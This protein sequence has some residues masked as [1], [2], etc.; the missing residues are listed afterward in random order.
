MI[1]VKVILPLPIRRYFKYFMPNF[2]HPIV[3]GRII[4]PFRS[5]EVVGIV[6]DFYHQMNTSQLNLK[7]VI[8]LIDTESCYNQNLFDI[9]IWISKNYY[10]PIGNVFFS[11]LPKLLRS[12]Y[13]PKKTYILKWYITKKGQELDLEYFKNKK[14]QLR[15]LL[16]LK[17]NSIFSTELKIYKLSKLILEKLE[18]QELCKVSI[19][20][21]ISIQKKLNIKIKQK[22]ILNQNILMI[23]NNILNK[24]QFKSYLLTRIH[25]RIKVKFY[26]GFI[27]TLLYRNMQILILV[28][29][30]KNIDIIFVFL[31]KYFNVS[32]N[33]FH[34]K[35]SSK[36]C[37]Q[38]WLQTKNDNNLIIIGTKKSIFLPF[39][40]IGAIICL[41]EH[42]LQYKNT[43]QCRHNFRDLGILRAYQE[44]IP[45]I[46]DSDTP[47]LKTLYNILY[48]KC[49]DI[50]LPQYQFISRYNYNIIDLK[51]EKIKFRLS[52][53]LINEIHKNFKNKQVLL[54]YNKLSLSCYILVC[55]KC[56]GLFKCFLC[57]DDF[58]INIH[59]N[60]LFCQFCLIKVEKP[61][62][63]YHC[64]HLKLVIKKINLEQIQNKIK[65]I[66]PKM[67]LLFLLKDTH[68][69]RDNFTISLSHPC[70]IISTEEIVE[71]YYFP[72]IQLISLICVD[73][74]SCSLN[75][76]SIEYF[77][78]F[79]AN[80][81]K[82]T[83]FRKESLKI[84]IQTSLIDDWNLKEICNNPYHIFS[85]K[86]LLFRKH[87]SL[88]PWS[89]Q[90]IIYS[91]SVCSTN[92]I[93]FLNLIRTI[94]EKK[95]N[96]YNIFLW[97][98]GPQKSLIFKNKTKNNYLI[99][100]CSSRVAMNFLLNESV[101]IINFFSISKR[102]KWF[103]DI[104]P[105]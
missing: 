15:A 101:D 37:L 90:S 40:N 43:H 63:C 82:L 22:I 91:E 12:N 66:F 8:S 1:I 41:E 31:K 9:L 71:N 62:F 19:E 100:Q 49:F 32:I 94:L 95:S 11:V 47:S 13:I 33:V 98:I 45:I 69:Y 50:N 36:K 35:L 83:R 88:P 57:Q 75:F 20:K 102:V 70:I 6:I 29:Y 46:L 38:V 18:H 80:L 60:T 99:M 87:Y 74:H 51:K 16:I 64:G 39:C 84:L 86:L 23:I 105:N 14:Q 24:K 26:L 68:I 65:K 76:R 7:S 5:K 42:H 25:L 56:S 44:N 52:L 81:N 61:R 34:S 4:V 93:I 55:N 67:P 89:C 58:E 28:P 30:I 17:K 59:H 3:G 53:T 48:K 73:H 72:N 97:L 27:K 54:I 77:A 104:E 21:N 96:Q 103:V 85:K 10:C 79:Y 2:M 78:Q 92:N